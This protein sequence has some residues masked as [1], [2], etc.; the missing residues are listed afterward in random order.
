[1]FDRIKN[2]LTIEKAYVL[3]REAVNVDMKAVHASLPNREDAVI[4]E[5]LREGQKAHG[6]ELHDVATMMLV[7]FLERFDFATRTEIHDVVGRWAA[8][9]QIQAQVFSIYSKRHK[10]AGWGTG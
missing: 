7:P 4:R 6:L 2:S 1:M 3:L 5:S 10:E 8:R 9:G